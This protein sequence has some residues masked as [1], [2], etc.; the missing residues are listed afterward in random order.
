QSDALGITLN[1]K[2][3]AAMEEFRVKS[4]IFGSAIDGLKVALGVALLPF[5]TVVVDK[6]TQMA[7]W[8]RTN[9]MESKQFAGVMKALGEAFRIVWGFLKGLLDA[10]KNFHDFLLKTVGEVMAARL[11]A[12][13]LVLALAAIAG[14]PV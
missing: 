13:L 11:E 4:N 2:T 12:D 1:G 3:L 14:G 9:F 6:L 10:G 8:L 7:G 5:L